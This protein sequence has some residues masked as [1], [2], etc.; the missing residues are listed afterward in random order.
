MRFVDDKRQAHGTGL[1]AQWRM[2]YRHGSA[3][4][5][6]NARQFVTGTEHTGF[7]R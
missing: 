1:Y 5:L 6:R 7:D 4:V 3:V 2:T